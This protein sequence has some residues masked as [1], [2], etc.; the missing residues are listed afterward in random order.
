[1]QTTILHIN[2][3]IRNK[4][5]KSRLRPF[6][7]LQKA[8]KHIKSGNRIVKPDFAKTLIHLQPLLSRSMI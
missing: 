6:L 8:Q 5:C 4:L 7:T 1:M 3:T 2:Y